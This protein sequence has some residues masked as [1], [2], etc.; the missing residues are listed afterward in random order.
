MSDFIKSK[1]LP[2]KII[3]GWFTSLAFYK[4]PTRVMISTLTTHIQ[5]PRQSSILGISSLVNTYCASTDDCLKI[6]EVHDII[7]KLESMIG[8]CS[9]STVD[10]DDKLALILKGL[11]NIGLLT[12]NGSALKKCYTS[13][14]NSIWVR[15]A[16]VETI[17]KMPCSIIQ[18]DFGLLRVFKDKQEDSEIRIGT[19][20][21]HFECLNDL[22]VQKIKELLSD[23]PVN[24]VG[25]FIWTH[26][27]N[28]QETKSKDQWKIYLKNVIGSEELQSK[29]NTDPRKFSRNIELSHFANELK[30]GATVD[31]N[32]IFSEKSY[33]PRSAMLNLT[34]NIFG[35]DIN[36]L[37]LGARVEGF[38]DTVESIFG[39]DGYFRE[40][41]VLKFVKSLRSKRD[42]T[43]I[44]ALQ[45]V[46]GGDVKS[47]EPRGNMYMRLFGKDLYYNSFN[48]LSS[49]MSN[50]IMKPLDYIGLNRGEN[51]LNFSK[52]AMFL[53][54]SII[55]PT[56]TGMPMNLT[57]NGTSSVKL[58]SETFLEIKDI[59]RTGKAVLKAKVYPTVTLEVSALMT[60]DAFVSKTGLKS[61]TKLHSSAYAD[62]YAEINKGKLFKVHVNLPTE[63]SEV[64]DASAEFFTY[65]SGNYKELET[66]HKQNVLDVCTPSIVG[67]IFGLEF[68]AKGAYHP[69]DGNFDPSWYFKGPSKAEVYQTKVDNFDKLVFEYTWDTDD[70]KP[71]KGI[72]QDIKLSLDTPGSMVKRNAYIHLKFDDIK[73]FFLIDLNMPLRKTQLEIRYD[74]AVKN[75]VIRLALKKDGNEILTQTNTLTSYP[76]K[77]EGS[78]QLIYMNSKIMD[79]K[80]TIYTGANKYSLDAELNGLYH[81]PIV[82]SAD[83]SKVR[84]LVKIASG[85]KASKSRID[86]ESKIILTD[87]GLKTETVMEY[88]LGSHEG[89]VNFFGKYSENQH[90]LLNKKS[91]SL[92]LQVKPFFSLTYFRQYF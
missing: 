41:S 45:N 5:D 77:H 75:K 12:D 67:D 33:I 84:N 4:N 43:S 76:N 73:T 54:G 23:E 21:A 25:S 39:P 62:V 7:E 15:L 29:W 55:I 57:V 34:T 70:S 53:D 2:D 71:E 65:N 68:C 66:I 24:Q 83:Y 90:G 3:D 18:K 72:M 74:W 46:F 37:E 47:E 85:I 52:S 13:K 63:K 87:F 59:F 40:D 92:S 26:L 81:E 91:F 20:L 28:V 1:A 79:W 60:L 9:S 36:I 10:K 19:Y 78:S 86:M 58:R 51:S 6:P 16:A 82:V 32:I 56:L 50:T 88:H 14:S 69:G 31:S 38:E 11:R 44:E 8:D 30:V 48:G 17:R 22:S 64:I 27:T 61:I 49:F 42:T 89:K 35:E 80:G